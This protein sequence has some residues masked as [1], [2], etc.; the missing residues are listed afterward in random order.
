M[1]KRDMPVKKNVAFEK[2]IPIKLPNTAMLNPDLNTVVKPIELMVD[3][4]SMLN[5]R[6]APD[7]K[8]GV[9]VVIK[10][11]TIVVVKNMVDDWLAINIPS[12]NV[13]GYIL[14]QYTS[15]ID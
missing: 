1:A 9:L 7:K 6:S 3:H 11:G 8:A 13:N 5:V 10:Q 14:A 12:L 15:E 4:C 2:N